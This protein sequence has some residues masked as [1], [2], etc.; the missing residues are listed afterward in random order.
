MQSYKTRYERKTTT[1]RHRQWL[2]AAMALVTFMMFSLAPLVQAQNYM[3]SVPELKMDVHV[4]RDASV[5]IAYDITFE[6]HGDPID[7]VDIG[8]PHSNYNFSTMSASIDGVPLDDIRTSEYIATGVEV[9]LEE[10]A[11]PSGQQ[12]RFRFECVMPDMVY[13]DTTNG[14]NASLR[15]TPTWFDG[16]VVQGT[17]TIQVAIHAM[18]GITLDELLYQDEKA[19]FTN[20]EM[21]GDK[22]VAFWQ[23]EQVSATH[24]HLVGISFPKRGMDRVVEMSAFTLFMK[25]A[26]ENLA[27]LVPI[28]WVVNLVAFGFLFFRFTGGTGFG[29]FIFLVVFLGNFLVAAQL[30]ICVLPIL[31]LLIAGN[32]TILRR[33]KQK[34][35]PAVVQ[36]EGGGIKR[37]LAAPEAAVLLELPRNKVLMLVLFG[38]LKKGVLRQ[39]QASPLKVKIVEAFRGTKDERAKVAQQK[40]IVLHAYEHAFLDTLE[41]EDYKAVHKIDFKDAME[42][43]IKHTVKRVK[44]FDLSDTQ[45]YYISII[46]RA[47]EQAEGIGDIP[48]R[49]K[50]LDRNLEW[51]IMN[52][53]YDRPFEMS[54]HTYRP[55]WMRTS[56]WGGIGAS[57]SGGGGGLSMGPSDSGSTSFGD[58]AGSFAGWTE[59]TMGKMADAVAPDF[60][61]ILDL[62]KFSSG[63]GGGGGGGGS[64]C[65]CACAGCACACACAGGGR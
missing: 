58:V 21:I 28:I 53:R 61:G 35:L 8:L 29:I 23:W 44:G 55:V 24:E 63:S 56:S 4:Q 36:V 12:G 13:Q 34:Y 33:R 22:A 57:S 48:E 16:S 64:G 47:T 5:Y 6:N 50:N 17:S 52:D 3:F 40:G 65:A 32:E 54:G 38:M 14:D 9:H 62:S 11:I 49:E 43:L 59:N 51:I 37:G 41:K 60:G 46:K 25:W 18:P 20:K 10:H 42:N 1:M 30:A 39:I 7:I 45:E 27:F 26:G 2:W 15:I 19:A 31:L